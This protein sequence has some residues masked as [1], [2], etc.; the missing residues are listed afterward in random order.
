MFCCA[1]EVRLLKICYRGQVT[2]DT[3]AV[4]VNYYY[5]SLRCHIRCRV[6]FHCLRYCSF[7]L[8]ILKPSGYN[9]IF[10]RSAQVLRLTLSGDSK[11]TDIAEVYY[12]DGRQISA[13]TVAVHYRRYMLV[14]SVF[15]KLLLCEVHHA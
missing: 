11:V 2:E 15:T 3:A 7:G 4:E 12:N 5:Y 8:N 1:S 9:A 6:F 13:A 10:C 14:G